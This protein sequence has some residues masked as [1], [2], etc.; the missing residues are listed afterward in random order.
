M[1]KRFLLILAV[2]VLGLGGIFWLTRNKA[3]APSGSSTPTNHQRNQG[4]SGVVLIEYGDFQCPACGSFYPI[5]KQLETQY[6]DRVTFQFR[7]LPLTQLHQNA[8]AG[9][10]AAEAAGKQNKFFEM[11]DKLYEENGAY[12]AAQQQGQ[13]YNTWINSSNAML[14][15]TDYATQLGLNVDKFRTDFASSEINSAIN[16]DRS[17]A[18]KKGYN[19]T[20]TFELDGKKIE[21]NPPDYASFAK[22]LDDAIKAKS[23]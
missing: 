7:H 2:I 11:H 13:T 23:Q 16:A 10:R 5:I 17:L 18:N 15:F 19:S 14:Y 6:S 3:S 22:V 20:P 4:S 12:Y 8:L 1:S 21:N 9:A